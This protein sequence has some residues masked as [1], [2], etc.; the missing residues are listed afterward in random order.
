MQA[1]ALKTFTITTKMYV[2]VI[3]QPQQLKE[4]QKQVENPSSN[5]EPAA[6]V[7]PTANGKGKG[8]MGGKKEEGKERDG[9][10]QGNEDKGEGRKG[11]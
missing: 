11:R 1:F 4:K 7:Y 10:W 3:Q 6:C 8:G 2:H 5:P 9:K